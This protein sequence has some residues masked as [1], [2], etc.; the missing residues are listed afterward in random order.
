MGPI[1]YGLCNSAV[2]AVIWI[3]G[4]CSFPPL[5]EPTE[6]HLK[7]PG[8]LLNQ[9]FKVPVEKSYLLTLHFTF[10]STEARLT[11]E[12]V[13]SRFDHN[14]GGETEYSKIP[15]QERLGLGRPLPLRILVKNSSNGSLVFEK[16]FHSLCSSGHATDDKWINVGRIPLKEGTFRIEVQ[17]VAPN[18][19]F[20][21]LKVTMALV[22]GN[23]K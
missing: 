6:V 22:S 14:C 16:T 10:P 21:G 2:G 3:T 23:A 5:I 11:D 1:T 4:L 7:N 15:E 19:A 9:E 8:L 17:N 20:D 18:P 12:V 13:G